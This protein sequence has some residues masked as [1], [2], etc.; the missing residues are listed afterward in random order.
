MQNDILVLTG[1]HYVRWIFFVKQNRDRRIRVV[2]VFNR[3]NSMK[4]FTNEFTI[5]YSSFLQKILDQKL[6][7][8]STSSVCNHSEKI[9]KV[10]SVDAWN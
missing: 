6:L 7:L 10:I 9:N 5:M 1:V 3:N 2:A 4:H 8:L